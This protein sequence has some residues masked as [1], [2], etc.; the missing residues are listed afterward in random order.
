MSLKFLSGQGIDGNV[1]IGTNTP[2]STLTVS[3]DAAGDSSWDKSGIL[4]ENT[5]TT[6]GEPT[7]AFRNAGTGGTGA[8]YW[9][10][11]LNQSNI[12]RLAYGTGFVDGNTMLALSSTG[13]LT[14]NA[15]TQGFLQTDA[16]GNV[17]TSG[18]G[19]LPGGPY[20]PLD[21]GTMT[22]DL[23][24]NDN[25]DLYLG[26]GN[27]FQ[28][29]HDGSNTYLRNLAGDFYIRQ[30]RV[31]ASMIFQCDDGAG[32]LE[33]YFQLEGASGGASPFTVFPDSST[34]AF[35]T[36]HDFRLY[37]N[38]SNNYQ[39]N[40]TGNIY[41]SNY[42]NDSNIQFSSDNGSG[43]TAA[44]ILLNGSTG[45]VILSH[46][47][48]T[49]LETT[50]TGVDITG[51]ITLPA[52]TGR[53]IVVGGD[54][55][56]DGANASIYLGNAPSSYGFDI[57]YTGTGSGN[58]NSLDIISTNAGS[59]VT[60]LK[61][62]QDGNATFGG[63][64]TVSG[65]F[66]TI[67]PTGNAILNINGTAD[68]FIEKDTGNDLYIA[69]NVGDKDIKFRIKDDTTN[70]IALTIDGSEGGNASFTG[71]VT[72]PT[73]LGDLNG[74]INTATTG[75]TQ[76]AG[77]D[78]TKI[79]T[80]AYVDSAV[81]GVPQGDITAVVAGDYLTGG[82]TSGSVTLNGDNTKLAHIVDS[83]N[84]S[85]TS[86]WI[87]VAQASASRKAGEIYVTD[88]ES[89]D[90]S[91]IRIDW[92]RSYADT[93]FT[94]LNCGG[95]ANRITGVRVLQETA[96][97]TYGKKYLQIQVT[98]TSNYYVI[99]TAPGTIPQYGDFIAETP[100][101][102]NTKTGYAVTGAQLEDLQNSS[103]GTH[104]GIT[105]G[106]E[107]YVN[108]T[109]D[110]YFLGNVGIGTASPISVLEISQQLSAASTIDYPY[111]I[112]SRDDGNLINQVGGE[113]VGIK[114]RIAG[115][116]ATTPGDS[117][118]GASIAAIRESGTD[119]DSST[120]LG[121]FVTQNDETLDEALRI[122]HD[123][124][125]KFNAYGIG[126][127][128]S[129]TDGNITVS[130]GGGQGG[131]FLKDTT[132]TFTGA[133]TIVGD[134]RG[135][136]QQ[137]ILNAG[138]SSSYATG[139]TGEYVYINAE[140]GLQINSSPDNWATGWAGRNI[141]TIGKAD[142][143]S[144]LPG[145]L[146]IPS[147]SKLLLDGGGN[148][149]IYE[150][151]NDRLRFF[152]GG[153]EFMRFTE[154]TANLISFFQPSAFSGLV[155]APTPANATDDNTLATTAFVKNLIAELPAGLIYKGAWN[156]DTNTPTLVAGGGEIK[157]GTTTTLTT[158]KLIDSSA[159]FTTAPA[160]AVNDRVR[161]VTPAGPEFAL[162]SSVDSATQLTLASDIVTAT[163]EAYIVETPAFLEEGNY[164]IVSDDGATDLNG[165]TDWKVGDWVVASSTN[166]WQKIDNSSVLDGSGTGGKIPI[167][168]GAGASI[169]LGDSVIT[170]SAAGDL[171]VGGGITADYFR[172]DLNTGEYSLITRSSAGNAPL[173]VQSADSSTNQPIAF[174][175]YGDA[176]ANAG[177]KV[178]SVAK[179]LS[180]FLNTNVGIGI[181]APTSK[182]HINQSVTNP[183]L[184]Q[185]N[186]FAVEIDSNHSGSAATTGD[187]EQGGLF[188]DV[189]SSTTGGD[190]ANEHRLYGIY[191]RVNHTGDSDLAYGIY[192]SVEQNTTAGTTT[193]LYAV[194]GTAISD[195]GSGAVL[196][197]IGG[198][199]GA[200]SMQDAT[201]VSIS[202][203]GSFFNNSIG[204]RT[205]ATTNSFG[206]KSE[207]Q[208]DSTSA[209]TDLFAGHF[210]IDS[211]AAYTATNSYLLYLD[212]AG[213]SLATNIYAIF[214]P[215]DVKSYHKGNF[216]IGINS[217][218]HK[219][220]IESDDESLLKIRNT[221][222]GGGA[223][224]EFNDN[225]TSAATQNGTITYYHSDVDSQGGGSSYWLEGENDQ[226]LVLAN[227]GRVV[228]QKTGS[229]TEVGYGFYDDINTGMYRIGADNLGFATG[230]VNRL[231][232]TNALA[233]FSGDLTVNGGDIILGGVGRVQGIDTVSASTDAVNKAYV[234]NN[235]APSVGFTRSG[236]NSSTY[237]ML[238][239]VAGDRLASVIEMTITGTSNSVVIASSFEIICNHSTDIHVRS[240]GG[241]YTNVTLKITSNNN[242]DYSIE[243]KHDGTTATEVEV[244][245]FPRAGE[246]ITPT[247][248][249]PAYTGAEYEHTAT[250]GWRFGGED[251]NVESSNVIVDGKIGVNTISP[252]AKLEVQGD[253]T[254][255]NTPQLIIASGGADNNSI[256]Q[257]SDDD[258]GQVSQIG[259]YEGNELTFAAQNSLIFKTSSST[260]IGSTNARM[261]IDSSGD[262]GIGTTN[263]ATIL[264]VMGAIPAANRTVPLDILT[265]TGEGSNNPYTGSGGGIVFKNRTYTYGLLKSARI[266][267][268]IDSD[269]SSNR[270]AGL[271]FEVTNLNQTY[272]TSLF[273]KYNGNVG[274][275]T[276]DPGA[277]LEVYGSSPNILINN[278][279]ETDS[280]IVF[281]DAQGGT[282]QRAAIKFNSSDNKLKFFVNDE[283]AQRMVIDTVG[284]V[285]IGLVAPVGKLDVYR[286]DATY[287]ANLSDTINRAGLIVKA[288]G[289][290]DSKIT[291]STGAGSR[292]YIQ[293]VNNAATTGRDICIN[294]YGGALGIGTTSPNTKLDLISGT[295]NGIRISATDTTSNWR[296]INIRSYVSQSEADALPEGIAIF[297]TNPSGQSDPAFSKYGG[298]V[299][300]CRDDGNSS[301]AIRVGS[302]LTTAF[303]INN[304]AAATFSSTVTATNFILSSDKKLKD[305]IK[306]ID[307]KHIDVNWKNFELKSEP[308]VKRSGVIAQELEE[309]HPE[310]VRTND[311]G[312]KSV[313]Y[314]DLLIAKIAELEAR[315]EK[316]GI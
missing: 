236:I 132:D 186:S 253:A 268:Y 14:L 67:N 2:T 187:R 235:T 39:E 114:F 119:T 155:T 105:V 307:T 264:E 44:Y 32:G 203:G 263:P 169:T 242:E 306:K 176:S 197:T 90:H 316:A 292:Q 222:N 259:T 285:G 205:G 200:T 83:S 42:A 265:I 98:A 15:Y 280:G 311:Q 314:I 225:G 304:T 46:Y 103:V 217:P 84:G 172:T 107:L 234:D 13:A 201:P 143:S 266:R 113:G 101:L 247:T 52:V 194:N 79:A 299:I 30:D 189:D 293:S 257:F 18:G 162:V 138:E 7:L 37:H 211:N 269:S 60:T 301:F 64:L 182:L 300:Q 228:V 298:T 297:T 31:D 256:L 261:V 57:Q 175:S 195:G 100:V 164:Y 240:M 29:Y 192:S 290:F 163:G 73:F 315:L 287:S 206:I 75:A 251:G 6:T 224:I 62:L 303:F 28:A 54:A 135:N 106:E 250:E 180:Y 183:D 74:T 212:Y 237:T 77:D 177:T 214:S 16:N 25:V 272:N 278:T 233:T 227:N 120:G 117:L 249:D 55:T 296:D 226:T 24:L 243:A 85:V 146:L 11:G 129:D 150:D 170:Q 111:T 184:D 270:G 193:N 96:D 149:Y 248:T 5:S 53:A 271:V 153:A 125:I 291:F 48:S 309:K 216:G 59:P 179:D 91:F 140:Q 19:T 88:G 123:R 174:F 294:P 130:S 80:T 273:L 127:L 61:I 289:S 99:V 93:N 9:F 219:L 161:V 43:G 63:N 288:S 223:A 92:M 108:G 310:F 283:V 21:G 33:T 210:S 230:G 35:G 115:N 207:I 112:S 68:S 191:N 139:Q 282:T 141:T 284:N 87:T 277:L 267:S 58:T 50:S 254:N 181:A 239:T 308:G 65:S 36:G 215:D 229:S 252:G 274:I 56:L 147:G 258:G 281:T 70:V 204:N 131:P 124:N 154:D 231:N 232:I 72:S 128:V 22:G 213:T 246:T 160:V 26:T 255:D 279:A 157:E 76:T 121:F 220:S 313:A 82:G 109:G 110:S 276:T 286:S 275:G 118:V 202:Y 159:A 136:S 10:T 23:K 262:V 89:S 167:W 3:S 86:G 165:I 49:K 97:V 133:L 95:H 238:C 104:E 173:Y 218:L 94:V 40:Y 178:L 12:Y 47:G 144:V 260:I 188:I 244:F 305:N 81:A 312:M 151:I 126:T 17:S 145:D 78:S 196:N 137:L 4:I 158:D 122:D 241:D 1:G 171:D 198:I 168:E 142:G 134:I 27:D 69:N 102:E 8:N 152:T 41:I 209:F 245:V 148:T 71:T 295:N 34:L 38:G 190:A 66:I 208:I 156:A 221:T 51:Q 185:P 199:Y 20:L 166:V 116:A 45:S 302:G